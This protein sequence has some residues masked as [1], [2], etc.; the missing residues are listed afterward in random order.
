MRNVSS[1]SF[2]RWIEVNTDALVHNLQEVRSLLKGNTRIIAVLKA[3]AYGL[4]AVETARVLARH[5]V[6]YFAVSFVHEAVEMRRNGIEGSILV[7]SPASPVE[8]R[9]ALE[10]DLTLTVASL[11]D[12]QLLS[13]V[14]SGCNRRLRI[15]LKLDTGLGRFGLRQPEALEVARLVQ[16]NGHLYLEGVY[17]HFAEAAARSPR[18]TFRQFTSFQKA[19]RDMARE[20]IE[21]PIRHCCNSAAA[22]RFPAMHL[23]AVRIGT[24]LGG[25]YP[26]GHVPT[27]LRLHNP[28]RFK[29][30]V[31]AVRE[32]PPG[33]YL[34]YYRTYRTPK[35]VRVAVVP[36]GFA[37][38][39][40]MEAVSRPGSLLDL[41]KIVAKLAGSYLNFKRLALKVKLEGGDY[42]VRGKVFMQFCLVEFP[43]GFPLKVGDVVEVPVKRT[44]AARDV[45][46]IYLQGGTPASVEVTEKRTASI[47]EEVSV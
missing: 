46:R 47:S 30:R 21:I 12:Y 20:G 43:V 45:A 41:L 36:V 29:A 19:L 34:G 26:A 3:E 35:P 14:T 10:Q 37:D 28:Y 5:G 40:G 13:T 39:L 44:L 25:Q 9:T 7:F 33:S 4:G 2:N 42:L 27:P 32:L 17:T 18:Y 15:H 38:G 11:A 23:D 31:V 1:W 8:A 6:D 24:L 16:A 22:L